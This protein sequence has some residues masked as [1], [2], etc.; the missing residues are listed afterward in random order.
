MPLRPVKPQ[1]LFRSVDVTAG[2]CSP[3]SCRTRTA[4]RF[5]G[6]ALGLQLH[7]NLVSFLAF[8]ACEQLP[9]FDPPDRGQCKG[10]FDPKAAAGADTTPACLSH[11]S[12]FS[13]TAASASTQTTA[14]TRLTHQIRA[15]AKGS[16]LTRLTHQ[17]ASGVGT[18]KN[19][20]RTLPP[21]A[22]CRRMASEA[23]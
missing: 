21:E 20:E 18:V 5:G 7:S 2:T 3:C 23:K 10:C 8:R 1:T 11:L 22:P 19:D 16:G 6:A 15:D 9:W 17:P 14:L 12:V 13:T 4:C